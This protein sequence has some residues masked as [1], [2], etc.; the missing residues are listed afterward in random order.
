MSSEPQPSSARVPVFISWSGERSHAVALL[1]KDWV[2]EVLQHTDPWLSSKDIDK[3]AL[4]LTKMNEALRNGVGLLV[5]T[6]ENKD[7]PWILFEAGAIWKAQSDNRCCP[8]L[9]DLEKPDVTGPL[10]QFQM[11]SLTKKDMLDLILTVNKASG[12]SA[13]DEARLTKAFDRSWP[14]YETK[15]QKA[16]EAAASNAVTKVT[17]VDSQRGLL[18]E[19]LETVRRIERGTSGGERLQERGPGGFSQF[20]MKSL[21]RPEPPPGAAP[22][23]EAGS[24]RTALQKLLDESIKTQIKS[25]AKGE[26]ERR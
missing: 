16:L 17:D 3:G 10:S 12:L 18:T 9:C 6:R 26:G 2:S 25:E 13:I 14:E 11:T 8:I 4:W 24:V 5:L 21:G 19:I 23:L 1:I 7:K 22:D 15:F 20:I